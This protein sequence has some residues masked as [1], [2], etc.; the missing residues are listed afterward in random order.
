MKNILFVNVVILVILNLTAI[1]NSQPRRLIGQLQTEIFDLVNQ[2][3]QSIVTVSSKSTRPYIVEKSNGLKSLFWD[4]REEKKDNLWIVG[5]GIVYNEDGFIIT[6]SSMLANFEEIKVTL[7]N[8][9]S[10]NATYIGTDEKT[11]LAI[12]KIDA[13][14]LKPVQLGNSDN[15]S[16]Y[17][18][19][20]VL[21]NS[22]GISPFASFGIVNG[23]TEEGLFIVSA[24]I[25]PGC[26]GAGIFNL[27]GE[28]IGIISAQLQS[29]IWLDGPGF[30]DYSN[31]NGLA[32]TSNQIRYI[33]DEIIKMHYE[34]KGWLGISIHQDSLVQGKIVVNSVIPGSPAQKCGLKKNDWL[35]KYNENYIAS[36]E[37]FA[38]QIEQ[39][40]P[41]TTV[42]IDF[43]RD[44]RTLKVFPEIARKQPDHFN[45]NKPRNILTDA[46]NYNYE[47]QRPYQPHIIISPA[48]FNQ[49]KSR[50]IDM[51]DEI[52]SLKARLNQ[53]D[54]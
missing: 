45:P 3:K 47:K 5:S 1:G 12:L 15:V 48:R 25:N 43:I 40:K 53:S 22:M 42:S 37:R 21:G 14:S 52:E 6:K 29:D 36:L 51:E 13:D 39:T 49:I 32:F 10:Y 2:T 8:K 11:G 33:L 24:P 18:I 38:K 4:E 9:T 27:N 35:L 16:I 7:Y 30:V 19:G 50:M 46:L 31:Q 44:D 23:I 26:S 54:R 17:S 41:G 20:M 34:Q 28:L